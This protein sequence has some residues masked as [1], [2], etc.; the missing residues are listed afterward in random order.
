[1]YSKILIVII[2]DNELEFNATPISGAVTSY[3]D[4][5]TILQGDFDVR[6]DFTL[7]K[8]SQPANTP[9]PNLQRCPKLEV[10]KVSDDSLVGSVWRVKGFKGAETDYNGFGKEQY[11]FGG[12]EFIV[13]PSG[14]SGEIPQ[15][16][17]AGALRA[18]RR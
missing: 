7:K 2:Q 13:E 10:R 17:S 11:S 14:P 5:R 12:G 9:N 3:M 18:T 15:P 6:V 1:M 16:V 4:S 8:F